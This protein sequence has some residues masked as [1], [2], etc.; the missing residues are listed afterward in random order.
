MV[1]KS[2][3]ELLRGIG[4]IAVNVRDLDRAVAFYRDLLGMRFLFAIPNAAFFDCGGIRLML[5]TAETP[6]LDHPASIVYY[7]VE[8]IETVAGELARAGVEIESE[9]HLV[10]RMPGHDL[11]MCFLRDSERNLLALMSEVQA[12]RQ[13]SSR[14][15]A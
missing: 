7:R 10:A 14:P 5:A 2:A 15:P 9:P 13:L 4:Q 12:Q 1:E 8:E 11:W 3:G 6:E